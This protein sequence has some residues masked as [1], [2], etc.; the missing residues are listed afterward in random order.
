L[1]GV[2]LAAAHLPSMDAGGIQSAAWKVLDAFHRDPLVSRL[3]PAQVGLGG[4]A[5]LHGLED[6]F[7]ADPPQKKA[8]TYLS[9]LTDSCQHLDRAVYVREVARDLVEGLTCESPDSLSVGRLRL[10]T[11]RLRRSLAGDP[12]VC[13]ILDPALQ[14]ASGFDN[15]RD[16]QG[17]LA[18]ALAVVGQLDQADPV[19]SAARALQDLA[20]ERLGEESWRA[21]RQALAT[22]AGQ[23]GTDLQVRLANSDA[24]FRLL[25]EGVT[26]PEH[27]TPRALAGRLAQGLS[28]DPDRL[29]RV[30]LEVAELAPPHPDLQLMTSLIEKAFDWDRADENENKRTGRLLGAL[31][32]A[33]TLGEGVSPDAIQQ[34]AAEIRR[35]GREAPEVLGY[36]IQRSGLNSL[37]EVARAGGSD[38]QRALLSDRPDEEQVLDYLAQEPPGLETAHLDADRVGHGLTLPERPELMDWFRERRIAVELCPTSNVEVYDPGDYSTPPPPPAYDFGPYPS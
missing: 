16:T 32:V 5:F 34:A 30:F 11:T 20:G 29:A 1:Y 8:P 21:G 3:D 24:A 2:L 22:L 14:Q 35:L 7:L 28:G 36:S 12:L 37:R 19:A 27:L 26:G 23:V 33:S 4:T 31:A 25:A 13:A 15:L 17:V 9:V 10:E 38:M 6:G 18:G